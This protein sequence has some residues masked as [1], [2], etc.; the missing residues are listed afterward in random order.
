[1]PV[2]YAFSRLGFGVSGTMVEL[3]PDTG[4][5]ALSTGWSVAGTRSYVCG[6]ESCRVRMDLESLKTGEPDIPGSSLEASVAVVR[7]S[8]GAVR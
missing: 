7:S 3:A 8:M 2:S 4:P 1:M 5:Y 6:L